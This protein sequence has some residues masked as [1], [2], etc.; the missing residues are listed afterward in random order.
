MAWSWSC[1]CY[2]E[3]LEWLPNVRLSVQPRQSLLAMSMQND[4]WWWRRRVWD[5]LEWSGQG[6]GAFW[7][8]EMKGRASIIMD[9]DLI[10]ADWESVWFQVCSWHW[11]VGSLVVHL[12]HFDLDETNVA[13]HDSRV[14][15]K[16]QWLDNVW[17]ISL[18]KPPSPV[19]CVA[20]TVFHWCC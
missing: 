15:G 9:F 20:E 18:P 6:S 4:F 8:W 19:I 11:E 1:L 7:N 14:C 5:N 10:A 17:L 16:L 2:S 3:S 12:S 13:L